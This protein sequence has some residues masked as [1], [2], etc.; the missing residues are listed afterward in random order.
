MAI[1]CTQHAFHGGASDAFIGTYAKHGFAI[2]AYFH[3]SDRFGIRP[4]AAGVF[5]IV[6]DFDLLAAR[7]QRL[8]ERG[9]RAVAFT[10]QGLA[11]AAVFDNGL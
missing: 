4:L 9:Q 6:N 10:G 8:D 11:L 7:H 1:D 2:N 5:M 3:V